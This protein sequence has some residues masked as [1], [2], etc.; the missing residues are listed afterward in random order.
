MPSNFNRL[1]LFEV[2]NN[3]ITPETTKCPLCKVNHE[4]GY[5]FERIHNILD[6]NVE[7][8]VLRKNIMNTNKSLNLDISSHIQLLNELISKIS[9]TNPVEN[10]PQ[11]LKDIENLKKYKKSLNH[12]L[13]LLSDD[14]IIENENGSITI[15]QISV[16]ELTPNWS[17]PIE[18][19]K[20]IM[21]YSEKLEPLEDISKVHGDLVTIRNSLK[22][23]FEQ[24]KKLKGLENILQEIE[25][26][27]KLFKKAKKESL[28]NLY[29]EI[30]DSF[31]KF[32][33]TIHPDENEISL[34]FKAE[35]SDSVELEAS[36]EDRRDSPLAYHSE[37][38]IDT[39]GICLFLALRDQLDTSGPNIVLLDDIIMSVDRNHRR[40]VARLLSN[41]FNDEVQ[42]IISTHEE[43]WTDQ[44][45]EHEVISTSNEFQIKD[46]H[47]SVGPMLKGGS[48]N[49]AWEIIEN[50][51]DESKT[52]AAIAHLRRQAEKIGMISSLKLKA[53]IPFKTKYT[54]AD[55]INGINGRI[56]KISSGV[57]GHHDDESKIW[58]KAKEIDDKR[59]QLF[60]DYRTKELNSMIHYNWHEWGQLSSGDLQDVVEHWKNIEDFLY[61]DDCGSI[62]HYEKSDRW[63]WICCNCRNIEIGYED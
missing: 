39:M 18:S 16:E 42:G 34:D 26:V 56:S 47:V 63:K 61:C 55:Y 44:L 57:K 1:E 15:K 38:H 32:Y 22:S 2:A 19:V 29:S 28:S 31:N 24:N 5:L 14:L 4:E 12:L 48:G 36:F 11:T 45:K 27:I 54:L 43:V 60:G 3:L 53:L 13:Q 6:D 46:W 59:S 9:K 10:H 23:I 51:L 37:G 35:M 50:Y 52:H 20:N 7:I 62:I 40:N 49:P 25:I 30:E 8:D 58:R 41:Y 21:E 17:A 33:S